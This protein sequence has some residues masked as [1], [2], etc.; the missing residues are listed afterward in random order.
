MNTQ[1]IM[2]LLGERIRE[3]RLSLGLS[4]EDL[5]KRSASSL[6]LIKELEWSMLKDIDLTTLGAIAN[7]MEQSI[8]DL[9][10]DHNAEKSV[11]ETVS[12]QN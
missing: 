12:R 2:K 7:A 8:S 11:A 5:A 1:K 3:R 10:T 9:V 4:I 6:D